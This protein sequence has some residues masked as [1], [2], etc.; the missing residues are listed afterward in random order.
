M[1]ED[2]VEKVKL[3]RFGFRLKLIGF[4]TFLSWFGIVTSLLVFIGSITVIGI[5]SLEKIILIPI[6]FVSILLIPYL[7]MWTFL[8][9]KTNRR[10]IMGIETLAK[11]YCYVIGTLEIVGTTAFIIIICYT[12]VILSVMSNECTEENCSHPP[13]E[14]IAIAV[15]K[16]ICG[17]V[18]L[19]MACLKIH[20][21]RLLKNKLLGAYLGF[22]Y[23]IAIIYFIS[24]IASIIKSDDLYFV[25]FGTI[26]RILML[27]MVTLFTIL[28]LGLINILY[29]IRAAR[30][31]VGFS[32][33]IKNVV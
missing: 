13:P 27:I 18:Y 21:I 2:F 3:T 16:L 23:V 19:I 25:M 6:I 4:S 30:K 28:D 11:V 33:K 20:G 15:G 31:K 14:M 12:F 29:G 10:N 22:R 32:Q 26:N 8:N 17:T 1:D 9:I 24:E 5:F 7:V